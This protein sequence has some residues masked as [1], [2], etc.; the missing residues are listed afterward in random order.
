MS[1]SGNR[2]RIRRFQLELSQ[3][4]PQFDQ[5]AAK[6]F[7]VA[8]NTEFKDSIYA[9]LC[10]PSM[11]LRL[12]VGTTLQNAPINHFHNLLDY[13]VVHGSALGEERMGLILPKPAG[14]P[15]FVSPEASITPMKED[16]LR[17]QVIKPVIDALFAFHD[18]LV[19]HGNLSPM[20]LWRNGAGQPVSLAQCF[21][22]PCGF[23]LSPFYET[24]DR[25]MAQPHAKGEGKVEDDLYSLGATL[26]VLAVGRNPFGHL[27]AEEIIKARLEVGSA[28]LLMNSGRIPAGL[29]ELVKGLLA[30]HPKSRWSLREISDW[31]D[32]QRLAPKAPIAIGKASRGFIFGTQE[33][34]RTRMLARAMAAAP[35][36]A[37]KTIKEP[38]FLRWCQRN[39]GLASE[40]IQKLTD[41][42]APAQLNS[43]PPAVT[44]AQA[45]ACIDP[46]G[47][48][49][50]KGLSVA[51]SGI[52]VALAAAFL[53][54]NTAAKAALAEM[55]QYEL[56]AF[57]VG[58]PGNGSAF[59]LN[60]LQELANQ[61]GSLTINQPGYG[62]ERVLYALNPH[63]P[64]Q[65][66]LCRG[67]YVLQVKDLLRALD[68]H[69]HQ[70]QRP[71]ELLDRHGAGFLGSR[72][73]SRSDDNLLKL[74]NPSQGLNEKRL[75]LLKLLGTLQARHKLGALP[76]LTAWLAE[77]VRPALDNL[78]SAA[79]KEDLGRS[80]G[81]IAKNGDLAELLATLD[82]NSLRDRDR[83]MFNTARDEYQRIQQQ[84]QEID[85]WLGQK[86][87]L[88][89]E[90]GRRVA[91]VVAIIGALFAVTV[92]MLAI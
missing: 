38:D 9:L 63:L 27:P 72:H 4:L 77:L 70:G 39:S 2:P 60:L 26:Y 81:R 66:D 53:Q 50:Y 91:S 22:A 34:F 33:Y 90:I 74:L 45:L 29:T 25:A 87:R 11:Q 83:K 61:R 55:I 52:G 31:S 44:L 56:P 67:Y 86:D 19:S 40:F 48:L 65:S 75:G 73:S 88:G 54:D 13:D 49:R 82:S 1:D 51:V 42:L 46:T 79:L 23:N 5:G 59:N 15:L 21:T 62:P 80:L 57:W 85:Q 76:Y 58:M 16:E 10:P 24:L 35:E 43:K 8:D 64:C 32:G 71:Q 6:A 28:A 3:P 18:R 68:G 37:Y 14:Q 47:P 30:D 7:A 36:E 89:Q 78:H 92:I 69:I 41:V 20:Q 84:I 17:Q 12:E